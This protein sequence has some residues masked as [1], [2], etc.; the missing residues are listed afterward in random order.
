MVKRRIAQ[1]D[2]ELEGEM[3]E[4]EE[5]GEEEEEEK[6]VEEREEKPQ[7]Q[8]TLRRHPIHFVLWQEPTLSTCQF[9]IAHLTE[10]QTFSIEIFHVTLSGA[11][12]NCNSFIPGTEREATLN[13]E[14]LFS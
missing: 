9:L 13:M 11:N 7:S 4:T 1:K 5:K 10:D 8:H 6:K 3:E 2:K 12:S 14:N